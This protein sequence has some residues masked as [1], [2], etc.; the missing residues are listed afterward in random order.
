MMKKYT[1]SIASLVAMCLTFVACSNDEPTSSVEVQVEDKGVYLEPG[2]KVLLDLNAELP[3][4]DEDGLR[5]FNYVVKNTG[6]ELRMQGKTVPVLCILSN[7]QGSLRRYLYID[8]QRTEQTAQDKQG[9]KFHLY[10]KQYELPEHDLFDERIDFSQGSHWYIMGFIGGLFDGQNKRMLFDPNGMNRLKA[11]VTNTNDSLEISQSITKD[12]PL[13]FPWTYLTVRR[14]H[15]NPAVA[16]A[17]KKIPD[18]KDR[19]RQIDTEEKDVLKF[20]S[21]GVMMRVEL[22]NQEA[23]A[24]NIHK[25]KL[26]SNA[27][28][29]SSGFFDLNRLPATTTGSNHAVN[30][31]MPTWHP[32]DNG[33][34][35]VFAMEKAGANNREDLVLRL[36]AGEKFRNSFL[37]WAMPITPTGG[38]RPKTHFMVEARRV[39]DNTE[40]KFPIM[41][42]L[43]VWGSIKQPSMDTGRQRI[44]VAAELY[45]PKMVLEYY[46]NGYK[47]GNDKNATFDPNPYYY[48]YTTAVQRRVPDGY[49]MMVNGELHALAGPGSRVLTYENLQQGLQKRGY[50]MNFNGTNVVTN[51]GWRRQGNTIY[52]LRFAFSGNDNKQFSAWRYRVEGDNTYIDNVYLGPKYKGSINDVADIMNPDFWSYHQDDI[53]TRQFNK[54][55]TKIT[56][57]QFLQ[58]IRSRGTETNH[59]FTATFMSWFKNGNQHFYRWYFDKNHNRQ[60]TTLDF[61]ASSNS[62]GIVSGGGG[63]AFNESYNVLD[64][65]LIVVENAGTPFPDDNHQ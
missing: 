37:V 45:R 49:H 59:N 41:K 30:A 50:P 27:L 42:N 51:D 39:V 14:E 6:P 23:Y 33:D 17:L 31:V 58:T 18:P 28:R 10:I 5:A 22:S 38:L 55:E 32:N 48:S 15:N 61:S 21:V 13:Y 11:V 64:A 16:V 63:Y 20:R 36:N 40:K 29:S 35:A 24:M 65:P 2:E 4:E 9:R 8:F 7:R 60:G 1:V 52:A 25:L 47:R 53:V 46:P 57:R 43:Y 44:K 62:R 19:N 56:D 54:A 26:Q 12:V 34:D 3:E